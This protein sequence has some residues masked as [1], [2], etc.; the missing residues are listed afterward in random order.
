[1]AAPSLHTDPPCSPSSEAPAHDHQLG[2]GLDGDLSIPPMPWAR[3][4]SLTSSQPSPL[5]GL[6]ARA[7]SGSWGHGEEVAGPGDGQPKCPCG[8]HRDACLGRLDPQIGGSTLSSSL[9]TPSGHET[10]D[11]AN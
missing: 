5:R 8:P 11:A 4:L 2:P 1:M 7:V 9:A 10:R 6:H 3:L